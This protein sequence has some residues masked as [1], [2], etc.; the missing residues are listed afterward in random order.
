MLAGTDPNAALSVTIDSEEEEGYVTQAIGDILK[1]IGRELTE[2][3]F[4]IERYIRHDMETINFPGLSINS[5]NPDVIALQESALKI[6]GSK[7]GKMNIDDMMTYLK[8]IVSDRDA[9]LLDIPYNLAIGAK[10]PFSYGL[11]L[12][13]VSPVSSE[14]EQQYNQC[15]GKLGHHLR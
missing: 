13:Y 9:S 5:E 1:P 4:I 8:G 2:G 11:R 7:L 15:I 14:R 3:G 12:S 10:Q 6:P